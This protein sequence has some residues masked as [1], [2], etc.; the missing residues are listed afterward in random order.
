MNKLTSDTPGR[1]EVS[2]SRPQF[3]RNTGLLGFLGFF[4]V[5][6]E[7]VPFKVYM[8]ITLVKD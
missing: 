6:N 3:L 1:N 5:S 8:E 2:I 4:S 7:K